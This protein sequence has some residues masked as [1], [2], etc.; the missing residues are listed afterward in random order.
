M[1][2]RGSCCVRCQPA[3][4]G[5][6]R[7]RSRMKN[8]KE[9]GWHSCGPGHRCARTLQGL[10]HTCSGC[11]SRRLSLTDTWEKKESTSYRYSRRS[12]QTV[13]FVL[14][15]FFLK[16]FRG[17]EH[18]PGR[19]GGQWVKQ[20]GLFKSC[21][22]YLL[23]KIFLFSFL[24]YLPL[25]PHGNNSSGVN[26]ARSTHASLKVNVLCKIT[27]QRPQGLQGKQDWGTVPQNFISDT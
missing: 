4:E 7:E 5:R 19:G 22:C 10:Q 23:L 13:G 1:Q 16:F 18:R 14:R 20:S 9:Q 21:L 12:A 8:R 15:D 25:Q 27:Q 6:G 11:G 24:L 3:W 26:S 17:S 2:R